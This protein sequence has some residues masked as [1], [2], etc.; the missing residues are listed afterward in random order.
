MQVKISARDGQG[1]RY[2]GVGCTAIVGIYL[3]LLQS[4]I[5]SYAGTEM[6]ASWLGRLIM[7][8]YAA[9]AIAAS[10]AAVRGKIDRR[11]IISISI[12][13]A[14]AFAPLLFHQN[15][16]GP[17][18]KS[19]IA[20][21]AAMSAMGI[22]AMMVDVRRMAQFSASLICVASVC[23][24]LDV[25]FYDGFS[26]AAGRAAF[27]YINPNVAA[28]T[29][30]LGA[31]ASAWSI[32]LKWLPAFLVLVAGAVFSTL[33]RSAM[34]MGALTLVACLPAASTGWREK[35]R[36]MKGGTRAAIITIVGVFL[37]LGVAL[38]NNPAFPVAL[39]SGY[40]GLTTIVKWIKVSNLYG[41]SP[42]GPA[43][44]AA[45]ATAIRMV[46][47]E[48]SASARAL[49]AE[50]ALH[51]FVNGPAMGIGLERAFALAP[52]NSYLLFADAFGYIGWFI[53]PALILTLLYF[54]GRRALPAATLITVAALFSHDLL[55]AMPLVSS[56][57]L[58]L[59]GAAS[60][61]RA[62]RI[63]GRGAEVTLAWVAIAIAVMCILTDVVEQSALP[64]YEHDF[65]GD[66]IKQLSGHEY[67]AP[68]PAVT[69]H[70]IF[71]LGAES[72]EYLGG[73][74][75]MV[76]ESGRTLLLDNR[77]PKEIASMGYGRFGYHNMWALLSSTDGTDPSTN[78]R[79]YHVSAVVTLHP[80]FL[81]CVAMSLAWSVLYAS[82]AFGLF[83]SA[84]RRRKKA[85]LSLIGDRGNP[86]Y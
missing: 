46:E 47:A 4:G 9:G 51:Q 85:L 24:L 58:I 81:L 59:T 37:L 29:L 80:L 32:P 34:L 78:G 76:Q 22:A 49:L 39:D 25:C 20:G 13:L 56:L 40:H 41:G 73:G 54:G 70:G 12:F 66:A 61:Y 28:L 38:D 35:I 21:I 53:V 75:I 43:D 23:C 42:S 15:Q 74:G 64:A 36:A 86:T 48:N 63:P 6:G 7:L 11:V 52:H 27:I 10:I 5:S 68:L 50:R 33:S 30:L 72:R 2:L 67:Y 62:D 45:M 71:R 55:F 82:N 60:E 1:V 3:S 84:E 26:N 31:V 16:V 83:H 77:S 79:V 14:F 18:T 44:N 17:V 65:S 8:L 57:A 19:Y 69:P